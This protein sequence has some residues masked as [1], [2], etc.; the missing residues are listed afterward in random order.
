MSFCK[1][2]YNWTNIYICTLERILF[3]IQ[4]IFRY[5]VT[6]VVTS[7]SLFCTKTQKSWLRTTGRKFII[8]WNFS[9]LSKFC[10][11]RKKENERFLIWA[12]KLITC[13]PASA[14]KIQCSP[15][16]NS[17]LKRGLVLHEVCS[18]HSHQTSA[19]IVQISKF[20]YFAL[21]WLKGGEKDREKPK[22]ILVFH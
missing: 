16:Y 12:M 14:G 10:N 11:R 17:S 5:L 9:I 20:H 22:P 19:G 8:T 7:S 18:K 15:W 4:K 21:P 3:L 1:S 6:A 13:F 2:S